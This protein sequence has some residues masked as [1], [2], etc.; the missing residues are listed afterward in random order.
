MTLNKRFLRVPHLLFL[1]LLLVQLIPNA[2]DGEYY[3]N[4]VAWFAVLLE[5]LFLIVSVFSKKPS[6]ISEV[7]KLLGVIEIVVILWVLFG[8]KF[9]KLNAKMFPA[10]G[11]VFH[12]FI[13][14]EEPLL[15]AAMLVALMM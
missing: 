3:T 10:P 8:Q 9:D 15:S 7:G 11:V 1:F 14:D 5:A 12:Q 4:Y 6:T 2:N 13:K